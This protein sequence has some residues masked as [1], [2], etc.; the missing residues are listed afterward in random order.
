MLLTEQG[1]EEPQ[2]ED[3]GSSVLDRTARCIW[4][5]LFRPDLRLHRCEV[6]VEGLVR[7][8]FAA[9]CPFILIQPK[10]K[11]QLREYV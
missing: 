8:S 3:E 11:H 2:S 5:E 9:F 10:P 7:G 6:A 1:L 4:F